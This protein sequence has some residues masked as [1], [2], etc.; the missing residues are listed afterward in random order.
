MKCASLFRTISKEDL[1]EE[2]SWMELHG[3]VGKYLRNKTRARVGCETDRIKQMLFD[4]KGGKFVLQSFRRYMKAVKTI[5]RTVRPWL[6]RFKSERESFVQNWR[7]REAL[8]LGGRRSQI[9]SDESKV[10]AVNTLWEHKRVD[11]RRAW[12]SWRE[13]NG[14]IENTLR[15]RIEVLE[16]SLCLNN[17]VPI[18]SDCYVNP[19][20]AEVEL[21]VVRARLASL[22][23]T[24][25]QFV[26]FIP[27]NALTEF[28]LDH[29][30]RKPGTLSCYSRSVSIFTTG[31]GAIRAPLAYKICGLFTGV[32]DNGT[33]STAD[34]STFLSK[35]YQF[36]KMNPSH[37]ETRSE[38]TALTA[39]SV[40][41]RVKVSK[42]CQT[43]RDSQWM[44]ALRM[45]ANDGVDE[46]ICFGGGSSL[47]SSSLRLPSSGRTS[48]R[49]SPLARA[50]TSPLCSTFS[51]PKASGNFPRRH[52]SEGM[53]ASPPPTKKRSGAGRSFLS[54]GSTST[55]GLT[56]SPHSSGCKPPPNNPTK[57]TGASL[58]TRQ[59]SFGEHFPI[60]DLVEATS[61]DGDSA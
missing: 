3:A 21:P 9:V 16:T 47:P 1:N 55:A 54:S 46:S 13:E 33:V 48:R 32:D 17:K 57:L 19:M 26:S 38:L 44:L 60:P 22:L 34:L 35:L 36:C 4:A 39:G 30:D 2:M 50:G 14:N 45:R 52:L 41:G 15:E 10:L 7:T 12:R 6:A 40:D 29:E 20:Q 11:Y 56:L 42:V 5:Q 27:I 8:K 28:A 51:L 23:A 53:A 24:R 49:S 18:H 37:A 61:E 31:K 43:I 59:L 25:P 58:R